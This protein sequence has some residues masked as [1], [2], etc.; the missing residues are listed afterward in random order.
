MRAFKIVFFLLC[1]GQASLAQITLRG[2]ITD[3]KGEALIGANIFLKNTFDGVS[4]DSTGKFS[5]V[6]S[7]QTQ[8]TLVASYMGYL[9]FEQKIDWQ[10]TQKLHL[11]LQEEASEL[12]MVVLSAGTFEASDEKRMT[13]LKPLDIVRTASANG[14]IFGALQT[15]PG[16]Q[17]V[18]ESEGL[19][20]RGG[21]A[22]ESKTF[23]DGMLIQNPF[24]SSMPDV[25]SRSRFSPFL[26]K[27]MAFS[28]GG[29]SAQY[30]QGLS[31]VLSLQS[32]DFPKE[33]NLNLFLSH[34]TWGATGTKLWKNTSVAVSGNYTNVGF[35]NKLVPQNIN[36]VKPFTGYGASVIL[37]QNVGENGLLKLFSNYGFSKASFYARDDKG[38]PAIFALDND[39]FYNSLTYQHELK[40]W[41]V[42]G[43]LSYSYNQDRIEF[44]G[45]K[46]RKAD[47]RLQARLVGKYD[48]GKNS[49]FVIGGEAHQYSFENKF[50]DF[51]SQVKE[52][53]Q[54]V[55]A[56]TELYLTH[57]L[58][59]RLG[60]RGEHSAYLQRFNIAPRLSLA[61]KT[62]T[63]TQISMAYGDFYQN[64][65]T[66]YLY[67]TNHLSFEKATHFILNYQ[68]TTQSYTF[69]TE[70]FYKNYSSLV[71]E[72]HNMPF[73][74]SPNRWIMGNNVDNSGNGFAQGMDIFWRDK[75]TIKNAD[76]WISY[77]FIDTKRLYQNF[78][79]KAMP[80]FAS[81]HN[82]S[83]VYKHFFP[84]LSADFNATYS[85]ASG[86]PYYNPNATQFLKDR[87]P[88][89]HNLSLAV[90]YLTTL[91][92]TSTIVICSVNNVLNREN[93]FG[94]RYSSTG[95]NRIAV[96]PPTLRSFFIGL[97]MTI[98]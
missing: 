11:R 65:E 75:Q 21:S 10:N 88:D 30:G 95:N 94:Y 24:F 26:F 5:L 34:L 4:T 47:D 9:N 89:F 28:T 81:T 44:G 15:L 46:I 97:S 50:N 52:E 85:Y 23:I 19:F 2:K 54:A 72:L 64:P 45:V 42:N 91:W 8:D 12:N 79:E 48:L 76:Y 69:R 3:T 93:I 53:Y 18:G 90:N 39:N 14:D 55:F 78:T 92:G 68:W 96:N 49:A 60:V 82:L 56:E 16:A 80:V 71:R 51:G 59:M 98:K 58:A 17:R 25:Q 31:S 62:G 32:E 57:K 41:T 6:V 67:V 36:W 66:K 73:D 33:T 83:V 13:I 63:N 70:T 27:G 40:K 74:A 61:Y 87:T 22:D 29:Y 86:R 84:K 77:S 38:T 37:R 1:W 20:V 35:A 43:G 7:D